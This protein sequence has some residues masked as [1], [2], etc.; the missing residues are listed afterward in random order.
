MARCFVASAPGTGS[1]SL[2]AAVPGYQTFAAAGVLNGASFSYNI[3]DFNGVAA[4]GFPYG[5][6]TGWEVGA[7]TFSSAGPT[8]VRGPLFS[9][10]GNIAIN[11]SANAQVWITALASDFSLADTVAANLVA[12]GVDQA[13]ALILTRQFNEVLT[14]APGTGVRIPDFMAFPGMQCK[15][16]GYGANDLLV[17]PLAGQ[18]FFS[19]GV[20]NGLNEALQL[21]AGQP[22]WLETA[23][24]STVYSLLP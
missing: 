19:G 21:N 7:T 22:M 17:Y 6:E 23:T 1:I 10:N 3:T 15:V 8:I 13:S 20:P 11:A 14:V 16:M 12:A 18:T 4:P 24:A 5:S 9:S 2:G